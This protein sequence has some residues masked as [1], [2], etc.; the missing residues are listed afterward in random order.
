[1]NN[2]IS[3]GQ[4]RKAVLCAQH[5]TSPHVVGHGAGNKFGICS[6]RVE[7]GLQRRMSTIAKHASKRRAKR[8]RKASQ[9]SQ[10]EQVV[11]GHELM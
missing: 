3:S 10:Q 8:A 9:E 6:G 5:P 4:L 2:N 11:G 7:V 1:M